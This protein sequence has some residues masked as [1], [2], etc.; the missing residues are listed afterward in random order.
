MQANAGSPSVLMRGL[1]RPASVFKV[2]FVCRVLY[3]NGEERKDAVP[4]FQGFRIFL[5][6]VRLSAYVALY[7][8]GSA[9]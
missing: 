2:L 7:T 1:N 6:G 3:R 9:G 8:F 5:W 4:V